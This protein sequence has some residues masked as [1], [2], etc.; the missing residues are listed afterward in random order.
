MR[1]DPYPQADAGSAAPSEEA[2]P[3]P[4]SEPESDP[5]PDP[6]GASDTPVEEEPVLGTSDDDRFE[7]L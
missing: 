1:V 6:P 7:P 4:E 5:E 3:E 2:E